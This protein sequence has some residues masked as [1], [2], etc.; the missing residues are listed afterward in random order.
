MKAVDDVKKLL[1]IS[2][3]IDNQQVLELITLFAD[4]WFS[5]DAYDRDKL[6][7]HGATKK[8]VALTAVKLNKA[9]IEF[10]QVLVTKGEATEIFGIERNKES[11]MGIVGNV[12]QSFDGNDLYPSIEEKAAHLLYFIIKNH[13]FV[14]GNKRSGAYAFI[15][16]LNQAKVLDLKRM[17]SP[18]LTA[19]T[20]LIAESSP[21][22]KEKM[23]ALVCT[24]LAK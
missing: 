5:L 17:T 9:L 14:D 15:W 24:V 10:K 16:F 11:V 1:P 20:L 4:T 21:K 3:S 23:I 8:K 7:T 13:P 19:L 12:M 22:D 18:A 6:V 2:T